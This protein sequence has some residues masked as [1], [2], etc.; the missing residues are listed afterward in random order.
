MK[1]FKRLFLSLLLILT[2]TFLF[3]NLFLFFKG[4]E[5]LTRHISQATHHDIALKKIWFR[6]PFNL[7]IEGLTIDGVSPARQVVIKLGFSNIFKSEFLIQYLGLKQ[8]VISLKRNEAGKVV[9]EGLRSMDSAQIVNLEPQPVQ[10]AGMPPGHHEDSLK[11]NQPG[12][13]L[14]RHIEFEDARLEF[15]EAS[16]PQANDT[17]A[18]GDIILNNIHMSIQN[19]TV[20]LESKIMRYALKG[21]L[22]IPHLKVEG[23]SVNSKGWLNLLKKDMEA[24]LSVSE[25]DQSASLTTHLV[26]QDNRMHVA[27]NIKVNNFL[28]DFSKNNSSESL[29]SM[30]FGALSSMGVEVGVDFAFDTAMDEFKLT[31]VSFSGNVVTK[32]LPS[33]EKTS[34]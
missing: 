23:K 4:K 16:Q 18:V 6:F 34:P 28:K 13:L 31:N 21:T 11:K 24:D 25:S 9:L 15:H 19:V 3:I 22:S 14:I 5:I 33:P 27:G 26:S 10:A 30:I 17:L 12:K 29:D 20:P 1:K 32:N 7:Y 2:V 8:S